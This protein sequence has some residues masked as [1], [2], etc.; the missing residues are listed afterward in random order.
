MLEM[1]APDRIWN[2][3]EF[4]KA[5]FEE[6]KQRHE[7]FHETAYNLEPN[8]KEGP[9]GLRDIQMISWVARRHLGSETLHGLVEHGF[10]SGA[11]H[12]D[13]IGGQRFL[14][15]VRFALHLLAGRAEDRLLFDFQRQI[16]EKFRLQR[17]PDQPGR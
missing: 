12:R 17:Q 7:R 10:I 16:A 2:A 15:R 6:Q 1:T 14:W 4:F 9:G 13:L 3:G 8:I 5:K 11:E